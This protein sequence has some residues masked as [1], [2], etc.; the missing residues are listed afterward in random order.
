MNGRITRMMVKDSDI[1]DTDAA[2]LEEQRQPSSHRSPRQV[3]ATLT[4]AGVIGMWEDRADIADSAEYARRL[5]A[6]VEGLIQS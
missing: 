3:I 2:V 6:E 4:N 1:E 5:R